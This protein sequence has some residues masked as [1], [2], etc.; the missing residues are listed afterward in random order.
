[1]KRKKLKELMDESSNSTHDTQQQASAIPTQLVVNSILE[2]VKMLLGMRTNE[3]LGPIVEAVA[4]LGTSV[5]LLDLKLDSV[6]YLLESKTIMKQ[7][8]GESSSTVGTKNQ[9]AD[10]SAQ[11]SDILAVPQHEYFAAHK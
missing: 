9:I 7:L 10:I 6:K 4:K 5:A 8:L 11:A 2:A 1:M 3:S